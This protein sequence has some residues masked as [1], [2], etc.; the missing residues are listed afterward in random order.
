M[1]TS[2]K[3]VHR[4]VLVVDTVDSA[5]AGYLDGFRY[6]GNVYMSTYLYAYYKY[7]YIYIYTYV[8]VM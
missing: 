5:R 6:S 4:F 2:C 3:C 8:H 7:V 1:Y